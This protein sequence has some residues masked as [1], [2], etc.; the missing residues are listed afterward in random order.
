[1]AARV[2]DGREHD[3]VIG[4][5]HPVLDEIADE[6]KHEVPH[7]GTGWT[8]SDG[9]R[10]GGSFE[11]CAGLLQFVVDGVRR[12]QTVPATPGTEER[13]VAPGAARQSALV[14]HDEGAGT[15]CRTTRIASVMLR[16][17]AIPSSNGRLPPGRASTYAASNSAFLSG[18]TRNILGRVERDVVALMILRCTV[19]PQHGQAP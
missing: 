5:V 8:Q 9:P 2:P 16:T 3:S 19:D 7:A 1:M 14:S 4:G 10:L 13:Q 11:A 12:A 15:L 6:R 18:V 17:S